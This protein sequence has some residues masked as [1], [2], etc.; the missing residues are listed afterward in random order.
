MLE[1]E[2][3][4][5]IQLL[6]IGQGQG[7]LLA[8]AIASARFQPRAV[9]GLTAIL[10]PLGCDSDEISSAVSGVQSKVLEEVS[11]DLK[12]RCIKVIVQSIANCWLLVSPAGAMVFIVSC[13]LPNKRCLGRRRP[14][15]M[16]V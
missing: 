2:F 13:F 4:S 10:Q 11:S 3:Q 7:Q 8:L 9:D 12:L 14:A 15:V 1:A 16:M 6:A 5:V